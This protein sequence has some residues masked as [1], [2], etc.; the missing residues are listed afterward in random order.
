MAPAGRYQ[1]TEG[2]LPDYPLNENVG[3]LGDEYWPRGSGVAPSVSGGDSLAEDGG[4]HPRE[5]V[6]TLGDNFWP[7]GSGIAPAGTDGHS[8]TEGWGADC[9]DIENARALGDEPWPRGTG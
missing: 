2:W 9:P 1:E 5:G 3:A 4:E 6:G 8:G 7:K